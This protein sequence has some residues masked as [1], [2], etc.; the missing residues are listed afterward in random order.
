MINQLGTPVFESLDALCQ[1][2]EDAKIS[3]FGSNT[4]TKEEWKQ[5]LNAE[6]FSYTVGN[7]TFI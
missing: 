6:F 2:C 5:M 3:V 7:I 1:Y 4:A